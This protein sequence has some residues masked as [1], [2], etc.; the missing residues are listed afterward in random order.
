MFPISMYISFNIVQD[1]KIMTAIFLAFHL[2][3]DLQ[4]KIRPGTYLPQVCYPYA[5]GR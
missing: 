1:S 2:D 5:T 3:I 4:V